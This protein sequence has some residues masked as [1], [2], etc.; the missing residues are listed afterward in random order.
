MTVHSQNNVLPSSVARPGTVTSRHRGVGICWYLVQKNQLKTRADFFASPFTR[1]FLLDFL[2]GVLENE[3]IILKAYDVAT[4]MRE[5][6]EGTLGNSKQPVVVIE[7]IIDHTI[8]V[9]AI[10]SIQYFL[11]NSLYLKVHL[12]RPEYQEITFWSQMLQI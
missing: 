4:V 1:I 12:Q 5:N 2:F 8:P 3:K 10:L 7:Y 11:K 9:I 6:I